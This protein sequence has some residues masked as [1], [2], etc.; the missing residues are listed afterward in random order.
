MTRTLVI[1]WVVG[2]VVYMTA[3][4]LSGYDGL[5]SLLYQPL[6]GAVISAIVVAMWTPVRMAVDIANF[7]P[8]SGARWTGVVFLA[9]LG[10][11]LLRLSAG[12]GFATLERDTDTGEAYRSLHFGLA[13]AGLSASVLA[14]LLIPETARRKSAA[15]K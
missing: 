7:L 13:Y 2:I 8:G 5:L 1:A 9:V 6:I 12:D 15:T 10:I 3:V 11:I 14:A 4:V